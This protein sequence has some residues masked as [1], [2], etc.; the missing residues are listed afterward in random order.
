M[1]NSALTKGFTLIELVITIAILGIL[2]SVALPSYLNYVV[3][4]RR[5]DAHIGLLAASQELERCRTQTFTYADCPINTNTPEGYYTIAASS[6]TATA[7]TLTATPV[8]GTSQAKDND[9]ATL[10]LKEDGL[11]DATAGSGGDKTA[12]W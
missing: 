11:G 10:I 12:C 2:A 4:S 5:T 6:M 3:K 9:C 7:F 8:S 1:Q